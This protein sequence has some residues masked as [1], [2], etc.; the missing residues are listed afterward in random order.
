V[1]QGD[2]SASILADDADIFTLS[3]HC[4][5]NFPFRKQTSDLDIELPVG[6][7]DEAYL[8]ILANTLPDLLTTFWPDLVLYDA[9]VDPHREDKL[10]KLA[11][12]DEGLFRRDTYVLENCVSRAIPVACVVGGGYDT[13]IDR[14]AQRHSLVHQ[15][16][17]E[18]FSHY[19][20]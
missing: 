1:H 10:G 11:L 8:R 5:D 19:R 16:A 14:L 12:S 18:I 17:S 6:T 7:E 20:L 3:L 13:D 9:G 2:G 15:A 4:G